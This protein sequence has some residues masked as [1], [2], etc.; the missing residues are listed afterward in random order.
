VHTEHAGGTWYTINLADEAQ[1]PL[2]RRSDHSD[3]KKEV[4]KFG[5]FVR[6]PLALM[7]AKSWEELGLFRTDNTHI[8]VAIVFSR[9]LLNVTIQNITDLDRP[10][11]A[12]AEH[13]ERNDSCVWTD[14]VKR[15][16]PTIKKEALD[17]I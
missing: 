13:V 16:R 2:A 9:G 15:R 10:V 1:T 5:M 12:G 17:H 4:Q 11:A 8:N 7:L 14:F 6:Q 3:L